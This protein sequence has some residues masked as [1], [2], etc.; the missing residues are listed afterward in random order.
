MQATFRDAGPEDAAD[1][2]ALRKV[3]FGETD[4][5][6]YAP[7]EYTVSVSDNAVQLEQ[8]AKSGHSRT[9]IACA[10]SELVGFL[11]VMGSPIPR[12]RHAAL[13]ALGV[14][15]SHWGQGVGS[16]LVKE[17]LRWA[18]SAALSRLELFV[19]VGN[20]RAI[21]LYEKF[22]FKREGSRRHAYIIHG[23]PVDD[24]LMAYVYV[25]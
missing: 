16:A 8:I 15:R 9:T 14:R 20:T 4:F 11:S 18:P 10:D 21:A 19:A 22:G 5:M 3:V 25:A 6:L 17:T 13:V 7:D 1:L 24:L 23:K 2:L 12:V